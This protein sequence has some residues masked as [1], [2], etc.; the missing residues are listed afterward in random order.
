M[1]TLDPSLMTCAARS[2]S[3]SGEST[4][5]VH[6]PRTAAWQLL[7]GVRRTEILLFLH[8][9][10]KDDAD[11]AATCGGGPPSTVDHD[12]DLLGGVDLDQV[13]ARDILEKCPQVDLLL[14]GR[15]P[16]AR[17]RVSDDRNDRCV[18]ELG[19]VEAV[20]QV[21]GTWPGGR[22]QTPGRW[23]NLPYAQAA[24]AASSS[25]RT[26]MKRGASSSDC[27]AFRSPLMP[28]PG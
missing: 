4:I 3:S 16:R 10:R 2:T 15:A 26:W 22:L 27:K 21:D 20:E 8:I 19:V 25:W 5:G 6:D 9:R 17:G 1:A 28:S 24:K 14:K 18:V 7:E 11:H 13:L 23:V 12:G